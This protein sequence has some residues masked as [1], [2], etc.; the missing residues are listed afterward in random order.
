MPEETEEMRE[1]FNITS[2]NLVMCE[3]SADMKFIEC[4]LVAHNIFEFQVAAIGGINE[5]RKFLSA[6]PLNRRFG[7]LSSIVLVSDNDTGHR[8][9]FHRLQQEVREAN[10]IE[11]LADYPIPQQPLVPIT[12]A[13][14]PAMIGTLLPWHDRK[15]NLEVLILDA[16]SEEWPEIKSQAENYVNANTTGG[17]NDDEKARAILH[18]IIA[19]TCKKESACSLT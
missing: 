2:P 16:F 5:Y 17:W 14:Y 19:V 11:P 3:G 4:L 7:N 13:G 10:R 8:D 9:P 18:A 6:L 12:N 1:D 15:G